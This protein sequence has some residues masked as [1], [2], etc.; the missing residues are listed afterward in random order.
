MVSAK[1]EGI[2]LWTMLGALVV[3][4]LLSAVLVPSIIGIVDYT[5]RQET[6]NR[7]AVLRS[8]IND[9]YEAHAMAIDDA[10]GAVIRFDGPQNVD[11]DR[12]HGFEPDLSVTFMPDGAP[13]IQS[14]FNVL[15]DYAI[16][17]GLNMALD[18][19]G[20]AWRVFVSQRLTGRW[21]GYDIPY[22][23]VAIVSSNGATNATGDAPQLDPGTA[24]NA[25]TGQL[26]LGGKD[27]GMVFTGYDIQRDKT[28]KT[29][30]Q[31]ETLTA[32]YREFYEFAQTSDS[33]GSLLRDYF[34]TPCPSD[35]YESRYDMASDVASTC[36]STFAYPAM[37]GIA[38]SVRSSASAC[39]GT[40]PVSAPGLGLM[41]ALSID[42]ATALSS[43]GGRIGMANA[44]AS[45][46]DGQSPRTPG[47]SS[48]V[49]RPP[50]TALLMAWM[51][52]GR[53]L[54]ASA[55][56]TVD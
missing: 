36:G 38:F 32:R 9:A 39:G 53:I 19:Y 16:E 42:D 45:D 2:A 8:A 27:Q 11:G 34:S 12:A 15:S 52:G 3:I 29:L 54:T 56:G 35:G 14:G 43:W 4:A 31:L 55:V 50:Y 13:V 48:S 47:L 1:A 25:K 20:N 24:F 5:D 30:K 44:N 49:N 26:T 41:S 33:Q 18:G 23:A 28:R 51:P 21:N 46:C 40:S 37:P 10:P 6:A 22:H 7:L 17:T